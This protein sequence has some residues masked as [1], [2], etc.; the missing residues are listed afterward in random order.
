MVQNF[1]GSEGQSANCAACLILGSSPTNVGIY[2]YKYEGQKA[3]AS[4]LASMCYT[5]SESEDHTGNKAC[6]REE[7]EGGSTL[8]LK[9]FTDVTISSKL[10]CQWL[11]KRDLSDHIEI[12]LSSLKKTLTHCLRLHYDPFLKHRSFREN[13]TRK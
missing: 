2:L 1:N 11:H 3:L 6:K 7:G 8:A 4:M 12:L 13:Q 5:R 9:H 10:G